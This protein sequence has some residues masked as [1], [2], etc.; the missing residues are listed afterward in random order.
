MAHCLH[1]TS[2]PN[3]HLSKDIITIYKK[4]FLFPQSL[5]CIQTALLHFS[6]YETEIG[7][8]D[9]RATASKPKPESSVSKL[10][11]VLRGQHSSL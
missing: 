3:L 8:S 5:L 6:V 9:A 1:T 11:G 7:T 2:F 4:S 10:M